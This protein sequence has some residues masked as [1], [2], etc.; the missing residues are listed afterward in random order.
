MGR[1]PSFMGCDRLLPL[2]GK[3]IK[4]GFRGIDDMRPVFKRPIRFNGSMGSDVSVP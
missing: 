2:T 3:P 4:G 1:T